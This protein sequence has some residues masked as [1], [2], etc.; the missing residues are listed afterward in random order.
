MDERWAAKTGHL[1]GTV[2]ILVVLALISWF[3]GLGP[4]SLPAFGLFLIVS[5]VGRRWFL[6][7]SLFYTQTAALVNGVTWGIILGLVY[8]AE[9]RFLGLSKG[10]SIGLLVWGTIGA[11]YSGYG[12][13]ARTIP[14]SRRNLDVIM[15]F[16]IVFFLVVSAVS[17]Y[18]IH[19]L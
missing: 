7:Q 17:I 5:D 15:L 11:A 12:E 14:V 1:L 8:Y 18:V 6:Y 3:L 13:P 16:A 19:W 10:I 2:Y 4:W 9:V